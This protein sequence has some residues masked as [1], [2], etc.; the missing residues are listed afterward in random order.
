[1]NF[2]FDVM[3]KLF[4]FTLP[5]QAAENVHL[6]DNIYNAI[7]LLSVVGFVGFV[8][9]MIYFV[10]RYH[11]T[12]NDKS[13]YIPHDARLETLW[14]VIPTILFVGIAIWGLYAFFGV[15]K[16]PENAY[17]I[18]AIAKQWSW[19]FEYEYEGKKFATANIMYVPVD[20][21]VVVEMTS[22]DVIHSFFV[23]SFRVKK[24]VVPG[25]RTYASFT[26][27]KVGDFRLFCAEFCG[28]NHSEMVGHIKVVPQKRF[29]RWA[30]REAQEANITDP[31]L[32][33]A[34]LFERKG[35][36]TCHSTDG[37]IKV[38]PS[39]KGLWGRTSEFSDGTS[40]VVDAA[41]IR[42]SIL[43]PQ[44][45]VVKGFPNSMNSFAGQ[46]SE[47]EIDSI[48]EFIKTIK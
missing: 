20:T 43:A 38:G 27:N 41:Y 26:P 7:M 45:K 21:P 28:T 25:M 18:K 31:V 12:Q 17:K 39:F 13:A 46:L 36:T 29:N 47:T 37:S 48:I 2:I 4:G 30:K 33:G 3:Q 19:E 44:A 15:H 32:L 23:P 6:V 11:H 35:C 34:R 40:Q 42:E 16:I 22:T 14:T 24:D 10:L 9:V 8:V 5:E 1:M